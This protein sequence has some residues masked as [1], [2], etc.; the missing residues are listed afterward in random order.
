MRQELTERR[1]GG[2]RT[3][4]DDLPALYAEFGVGEEGKQRFDQLLNKLS[5]TGEWGQRAAEILRAREAGR[6]QQ[7][8]AEEIRKN[9]GVTLNITKAERRALKPLR[10]MRDSELVALPRLGFRSGAGT[11]WNNPLEIVNQYGGRQQFDDLLNNLTKIKSDEQPEWG[12][13]LSDILRRLVAGELQRE[14]ALGYE[15]TVALVSLLGYQALEALDM[16]EAGEEVIPPSR[17]KHNLAKRVSDITGRYGKPEVFW[18]R[19]EQFEAVFWKMLEKKEFDKANQVAEGLAILRAHAGGMSLE[20]I[21][22]A[23]GGGKPFEPLTRER[24]RQLEGW[25]LENLDRLS[26]GEEVEFR[27]PKGRPRKT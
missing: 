10:E 19:L 7:E 5:L 15:T 17:G 13:R 24:V 2:M 4:W 12:K 23:L 18:N 26:R 21:G 9:F 22:R 20:D 1:K 27:K 3:V 11:I 6:T 25:A 14:I 8:V 16:L